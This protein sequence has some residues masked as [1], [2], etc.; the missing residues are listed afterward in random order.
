[1][2]PEDILAATVAETHN[3]TDVTTAHLSGDVTHL[4]GDVTQ[5]FDEG[6]CQISEWLEKTA[7]T[8]DLQ[9]G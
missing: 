4:S 9:V 3:S 2:N 8:L 1:M 5:Q 6:V 7:N